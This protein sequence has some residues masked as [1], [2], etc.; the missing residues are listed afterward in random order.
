MKQFELNKAGWET[1]TDYI[2]SLENKDKYIIEVKKKHRS[3]EQLKYY[4]GALL[5]ALLYFI[6][7]EIKINNTDNIFIYTLKSFTVMRISRNTIKK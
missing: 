5:P 3:Y 7:D 6:K 1:L 2:K 4:F